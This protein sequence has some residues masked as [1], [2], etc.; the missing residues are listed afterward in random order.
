MS[1]KRKTTGD[2]LSAQIVAHK[3]TEEALRL[4][5]KH[6]RQ[7][8]KN[9]PIPVIMQAEDGVVLEISEIWTELTGYTRDEMKAVNDWLNLAFGHGADAVREHVRGLFAGESSI[10]PTEFEIETPSGECR[11][12]VFSAWPVGPL[13]DGRR[14]I[15]GTALD[16]TDRKRA[17]QATARLAALVEFSDGSII[18]TTLVSSRRGTKC[19]RLFGYTGRKRS[20]SRSRCSFLITLMKQHPGRIRRGESVQHCA[21]AQCRRTL[22]DISL[23]VSPIFDRQGD[24]RR[25][26]SCSRHHPAHPGRTGFARVG[27]KLPDAIRF[28]GRGLLRHRSLV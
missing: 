12:W 11:C 1:K 28:D 26:K 20:A 5:E 3:R 7:S 8:I 10:E 18:S 17:E 19:R 22:L 23:T 2:Q 9:A 13:L 21:G 24:R 15:V 6:F 14:Y 4:S 27:R 16:F 25:V